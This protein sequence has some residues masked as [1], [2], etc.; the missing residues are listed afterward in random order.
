MNQEENTFFSKN[1]KIILSLRV[2]TCQRDAFII[3]EVF[4]SFLWE[5]KIKRKQEVVK[6][7]KKSAPFLFRERQSRKLS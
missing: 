6:W 2:W 7:Q 1:K 5:E 3:I 4:C